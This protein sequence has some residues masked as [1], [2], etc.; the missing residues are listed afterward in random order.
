MRQWLFVIAG[1]LIAAGT[2]F[3]VVSRTPEDRTVL[4]DDGRVTL[5]GSFDSTQSV[6]LSTLPTSTAPFTAVVGPVYQLLPDHL[7]FTRDSQLSMKYSDLGISAMDAYRLQIG[8]YDDSI[9][10]WQPLDSDVDPSRGL[11][12][13]NIRQFA[14]YALLLPGQVAR[15]N[16]EQ[17]TQKLIDAPPAGAVGYETFVGYATA[18]GDYVL[19]P[20]L[21][22]SGGCA[23]KFVTGENGKP[24]M[25]TSM[26]VHFG[27]HL[28][29]E[30]VARWQIGSGCQGLAV[31]E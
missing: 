8:W 24:T 25:L 9:T 27:D 1:I 23:G 15:P 16:L 28:D 7:S 12:T 21:G 22:K 26:S 29:Y 20:G 18:P 4:S 14:R 6:A 19:L 31:I 13:A 2:I 5:L 17:E 11:V 30:V 3:I 10:M